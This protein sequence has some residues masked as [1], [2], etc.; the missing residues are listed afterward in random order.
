MRISREVDGRE[1][2][3]PHQTRGRPFVQSHN[4]QLSDDVNRALFQLI[5]GGLGSFSLHLQPDL[6]DLEWVREHELATTSGTTS[7][8]LPP[9]L[10]PASLRI[11]SNTTNEI[12]DSELDR[13]LRGNTLWT[14]FISAQSFCLFEKGRGTRGSFSSQLAAVR[15]HD[16]NPGNPRDGTLC[17]RNRYCSYITTVRR[18]CSS[19]FACY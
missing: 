16:R 18:P 6:Y 13:F 1:R 14:L 10:D 2:D 5:R 9:K 7:H 3:V 11:C 12:I 19:D 4:A 8:H 15:D 17:E